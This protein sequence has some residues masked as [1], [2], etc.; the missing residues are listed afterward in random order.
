MA[1]VVRFHE[2]GGPEVLRLEDVLVPDPGPDELKIKVEAIG[3]NRAE[4][5]FRSGRY[6]ESP[7]FPSGLG[8]EA[9]G[10]IIAIGSAQRKFVL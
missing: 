9:A 4:L 1:T 6:L 8:Y 3:L 2:V 7:K 5:A 10:T